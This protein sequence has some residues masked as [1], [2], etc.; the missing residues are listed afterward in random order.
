MLNNLVGNALR[1]TPPGGQVTVK[2]VREIDAVLVTICDNGEGIQ[3]DDID[4]VFDRFYRGEK[5]R[6][7][8]T[9]GSGLGLAIARG[10]VEAHGGTIRV[11]SERGKGACFS[12]KLPCENC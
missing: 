2:A 11:E 9:G 8:A 10:I 3:P 5:S 1:H 7:R 12:F 6:S 4:H